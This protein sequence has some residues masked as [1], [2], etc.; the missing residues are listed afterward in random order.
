MKAKMIRKLDA[1]L[2]NNNVKIGGDRMLPKMRITG[3][4][5]EMFVAGDLITQGMI[6]AFPSI[7]NTAYDLLAEKDGVAYRVQIKSSS[8]DGEKVKFDLTRPSA[9]NRYYDKSDFDIL[10]LYDF[11]SKQIAYLTWVT[12]PHK[13]SITLRYVD[14]V[15]KNA[16]VAGN[17]R[18]F[19]N[20]FSTFPD[21]V[22]TGEVV[23]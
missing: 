3:A 6:P 21:E 9:S 13:R 22:K 4:A 16:F 5:A 7:E 8:G 11:N 10:A 14:T 18:L 1:T 15:T 2:S 23:A 19:F 17:G 20:D 12:L